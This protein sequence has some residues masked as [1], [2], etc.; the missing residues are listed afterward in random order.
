VILRA[1]NRSA[2]YGKGRPVLSG[3]SAAFFPGELTAVIGPNG[4]GKSTLIRLLAGIDRP[5]AGGVVSLDG[6]PLADWR[7]SARAIRLACLPQ[8]E[9]V[10]AGFTVGELTALG[11]RAGGAR[12]PSAVAT[13]LR[14]VGLDPFADRRIETLSEGQRQRA[15]LARVYAQ[16]RGWADGPGVVLADEP[17]AALDPGFELDAMGAFRELA[18]RGRTV[19]VV[20]HDINLARRFAHR[21]LVLTPSGAVAADAAVGESLTPAVLSG[22]FGVSWSEATL[23]DGSVVVIPADRNPTI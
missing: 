22:V 3:I 16:S 11:A 17:A 9:E 23:G 2:A 20:L 19:V 13:A 1:D 8:R 14:R 10:A 18:G 7:P 15:G 21:A 12:E 6:V 5:A 4:A